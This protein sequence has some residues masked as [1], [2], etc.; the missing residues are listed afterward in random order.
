MDIAVRIKRVLIT[1][2]VLLGAVVAFCF[3]GLLVIVGSA[4]AFSGS[5]GSAWRAFLQS[6]APLAHFGAGAVAAGGLV[7]L[8]SAAAAS[9]GLWARSIAAGSVVGGIVSVLIPPLGNALLSLSNP[10]LAVL[11]KVF[12]NK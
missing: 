7:A 10:I 11:G 6:L 3:V 8:V 1:S 4:I 9:H 5:T 12:L 2:A